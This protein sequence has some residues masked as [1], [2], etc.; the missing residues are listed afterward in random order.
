[1]PGRCRGPQPVTQ[2]RMHRGRKSRSLRFLRFR[3]ELCLLKALARKRDEI[4]VCRHN[5]REYD[6]QPL[7]NRLMLLWASTTATGFL[8]TEQRQSIVDAALGEQHDDGGWSTAS[9]GAWKRIDGSAL[10]TRSDGYATGIAT[11]AL[12][13]AGLSARDAHVA[14]GLDWLNRN[15]VR[16]TGQWTASPSSRARS[17]PDDTTITVLP[18]VWPGAAMVSIAGRSGPLPDHGSS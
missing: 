18:G 9:L 11:L 10:D 16:A 15:Q 6:H 12:Q 3:P 2:Q 8:S 17:A 5:A 7:F 13:R 4:P 14:S 1:M